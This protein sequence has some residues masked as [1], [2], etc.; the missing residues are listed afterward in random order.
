MGEKRV[1]SGESNLNEL[2]DQIFLWGEPKQSPA[3][4]KNLS[5]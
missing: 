4:K 2:R 1:E 3:E 5:Q